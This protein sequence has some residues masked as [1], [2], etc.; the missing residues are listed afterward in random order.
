MALKVT[1]RPEFE[2]LIERLIESGRY[3]IPGEV[4]DDALFFFE[5]RE[6]ANDAKLELLRAEIQKGIDSGPAEEIDPKTWIE[7][8]KADGRRELAAE[9]DAKKVS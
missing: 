6:L 1:I 8:I 9:K 5:K 3:S 4:V 7:K 2:A